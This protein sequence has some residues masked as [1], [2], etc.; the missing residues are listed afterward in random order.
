[1]AAYPNVNA[2]TANKESWKLIRKDAIKARI[3]ELQHERFE[4]LS[5]NA[6]SIATQLKEIALSEDASYS[7]RMRALELIQKQMGLQT[8][9]VEADIKT[10]TITVGL[11]DD[12]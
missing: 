11:E 2:K 9:K 7:E 4:A 1:M 12:E 8:Q 6:D 10:T 5:I 3:R